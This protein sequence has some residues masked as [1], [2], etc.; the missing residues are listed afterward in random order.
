MLNIFAVNGFTYGLTACRVGGKLLLLLLRLRCCMCL[1]LI[2]VLTSEVAHAAHK[3]NSKL[4]MLHQ[5]ATHLPQKHRQ[6]KRQSE[7]EV[8]PD[9]GK[10]LL[11]ET[12]HT[13][14]CPVGDTHTHTHT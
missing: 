6:R 4:R 7:S 13:T 10:R 8:G 3:T 2:A 11:G 14:A 9:D 1:I 12:A 5:L